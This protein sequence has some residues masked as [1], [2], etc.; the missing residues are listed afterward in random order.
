M[1]LICCTWCWYRQTNNTLRFAI[2]CTSS[3]RLASCCCYVLD[4]L[5][6]FLLK[7]KQRCNSDAAVAAGELTHNMEC[8]CSSFVTM[9][10]RSNAMTSTVGASAITWHRLSCSTVDTLRG[11][12]MGCACLRSKHTHSLCKLRSKES[13]KSQYCACQVVHLVLHVVF[14]PF[15]LLIVVQVPAKLHC[16]GVIDKTKS[17]RVQSDGT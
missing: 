6:H 9:A 10:V 17:W 15:L 7:H 3:S 2:Q 4:D 1:I 5:L 11:T 14:C 8:I 13:R 12:H 16:S